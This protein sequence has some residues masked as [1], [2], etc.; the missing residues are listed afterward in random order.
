MWKDT[1]RQ[2]TINDGSLRK[3]REKERK[4]EKGDRRG[5]E[6]HSSVDFNCTAGHHSTHTGGAELQKRKERKSDSERKDERIERRKESGSQ[7]RG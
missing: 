7:K 2:E 3:E 1:I 6:P 5:N 4:S